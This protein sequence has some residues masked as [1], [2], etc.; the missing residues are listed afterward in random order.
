[1]S[2]LKYCGTCRATEGQLVEVKNQDVCQ[3]HGGR[4]LQVLRPAGSDWRLW[5]S[6]QCHH[7]AQWVNFSHI[8]HTLIDVF[9]L[10]QHFWYNVLS[11]KILP[12][13]ILS[14]CLAQLFHLQVRQEQHSWRNLFPHGHHQSLP[15]QGWKPSGQQ[16]P[17]FEIFLCWKSQSTFCSGFGV[18]E[19]TSRCNKGIRVHHIWQQGQKTVSFVRFSL[20][21][22]VQK[23]QSRKMSLMGVPPPPLTES[24]WPKS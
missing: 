3:D 18:Q 21:K 23:P 15:C 20:F 12:T 5:S 4:G 14:A 17:C 1:M 8:C 7:R 16:T 24:D 19:R 13:K 22:S 6:L 11:K 9:Y 2:A 10:D